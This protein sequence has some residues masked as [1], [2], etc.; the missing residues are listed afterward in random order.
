LRLG[1]RLG[2]G[3]LLVISRK[4]ILSWSPE[5]LVEGFGDF[6][7]FPLVTIISAPPAIGGPSSARFKVGASL[8]TP[9]IDV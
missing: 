3:L 2:L 6:F 8:V 7:V 9:V 4:P 1:L 5:S